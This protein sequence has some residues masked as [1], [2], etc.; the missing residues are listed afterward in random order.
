MNCWAGKL[1]GKQHLEQAELLAPTSVCTK[2]TLWERSSR[3][4]LNIS[5]TPSFSAMSSMM[6]M[7]IKHPVLPAPA[8][9][10]KKTRRICVTKGLWKGRALW[11]RE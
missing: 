5:T 3:T 7:A 10:K 4:Q 11:R 9:E 1:T 2:L 8:L 6:S